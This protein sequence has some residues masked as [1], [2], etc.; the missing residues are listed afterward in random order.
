MGGQ[1]DWGEAHGD[2]HSVADCCAGPYDFV[3]FL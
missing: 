1:V 3:P 2:A